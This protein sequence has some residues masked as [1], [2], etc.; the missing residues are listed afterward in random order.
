MATLGTRR[1]Y[2]GSIASDRTG[3]AT[4]TAAFSRGLQ[5]YRR[6]GTFAL[7]LGYRQRNTEAKATSTVFSRLSSVS[8]S[9]TPPPPIKKAN[10]VCRNRFLMSTVG[11]SPDRSFCMRPPES[12][13]APAISQD[14]AVALAIRGVLGRDDATS[15]RVHG[16]SQSPLYGAA[17]GRLVA[18]ALGESFASRRLR[19]HLRFSFVDMHRDTH[20]FPLFRNTELSARGGFGTTLPFVEHAGKYVLCFEWQCFNLLR[21]ATHGVVNEIDRAVWCTHNHIDPPLRFR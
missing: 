10:R 16:R 21:V 8:H 7:A 5:Q 9:P 11:L 13:G 19:V 6:Y 3:F 1:A 2:G 17:S 14:A 4:S 20:C 12:G 18:P 15:F